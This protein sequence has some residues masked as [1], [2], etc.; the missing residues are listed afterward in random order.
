[1]TDL[2]QFDDEFDVEYSKGP[3]L[4]APVVVRQ[5]YLQD[6]IDRITSRYR[7]KPKYLAMMK[8]VLQPF[9]DI[10]NLQA[11]IPTYFFDIDSAVGPQ[12]DAVG[13]RVGLARA[14]SVPLANVYFSFDDALLGWD[15]GVW[16]GPYGTDYGIVSLD[17]DTYRHLLYTKRAANYWDGTVEQAQSILN[18]FVDDDA[19][20]VMYVENI[21]SSAPNSFF[22]FDSP[23]VQCGWDAGTWYAAGDTLASIETAK[24][25]V[26]IAVSGKLPELALMFLLA[27]DAIPLKPNG[28]PIEYRFTSVNETPIFGFDVQSEKIAGWESGSWGVS[29]DYVAANVTV[30]S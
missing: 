20:H 10:Q 3:I 19:T 27:Q 6:Y 29:A 4:A 26:A 12:L 18:D 25:S 13:V 8:L 23:D 17:D 9:V 24:P 5:R 21:Q 16:K 1:M 14:V 22:M 2:N 28:V 7:H 30:G 15:R 11:R